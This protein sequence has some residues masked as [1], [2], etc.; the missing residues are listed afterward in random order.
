MVKLGFPVAGRAA[1]C[2][3][4]GVYQIST[5]RG[6]LRREITQQY[7]NIIMQMY[8]R[9][10]QTFALRSPFLPTSITKSSPIGPLR[11]CV[12][13][14]QRTTHSQAWRSLSPGRPTMAGLSCRRTDQGGTNVWRTTAG[15]CSAARWRTCWTQSKA[16]EINRLTA[17]TDMNRLLRTCFTLIMP[18]SLMDIYIFALRHCSFNEKQYLVQLIVTEVCVNVLLLL[19][20]RWFPRMSPSRSV[21]TKRRTFTIPGCSG[22]R[23]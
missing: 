5:W 1:G 21:Q 9:I 11:M 6:K 20:D 19:S 7:V 16:L 12:P 13:A 15:G 10:S 23:M 8:L 4:W 3:C 14:A 2:C 22:N 18:N 17:T